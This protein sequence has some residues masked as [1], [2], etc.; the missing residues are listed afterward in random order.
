MDSPFKSPIILSLCTGIRGLERGLILAL[1]DIRIAA[2]VENEAFV[3]EN[4]LTAMEAGMVAPSPIWTNLK[5]FPFGKFQHRIHGIIGGYPCT[6]FSVAGLR[7]GENDPR[8]LWPFIR[9]GIQSARPIF[10][11]FENSDDHISLGYDTVYKDLREMGYRVE[12]G[13]FSAEEAGSPHE[14]Q[15]LFILA[16]LADSNV[17][18]TGRSIGNLLYQEGESLVEEDQRQRY[19]DEPGACGAAVADTGSQRIRKSSGGHQSEQLKSDGVQRGDEELAHPSIGGNEVGHD[20][21]S[22]REFEQ[23]GSTKELE[24]AGSIRERRRSNGDKG[25]RSRKGDAEGSGSELVNTQGQR[26]EGQPNVSG[27]T[28]EKSDREK[29]WS[30]PIG[31]DTAF[32][33]WPAGQG[34]EQYSYEPPRTIESRLEYN[35]AGYNA[36]G[37]LHRAIGNSV[38]RQTAAIAFINL[39]NKHIKNGNR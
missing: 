1:G 20:K 29:Q 14:R 10:C 21:P 26:C 7:K 38:V 2:Y 33:G 24:N 25:R 15:R 13:I 11:F 6:P 28:G 34:P 27:S 9:K 5:T 16:I 22:A 39:L 37:D 32:Q 19:R 30:W 12:A 8:H 23:N 4:L 31:T 17:Y 35:V 36:V 3:I 18:D